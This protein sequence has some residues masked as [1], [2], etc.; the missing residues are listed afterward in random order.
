MKRK[1]HCTRVELARLHGR[2]P[3]S[4]LSPWPWQAHCCQSE[5]RSKPAF[6]F[7]ALSQ[8]AQPCDNVNIVSHETGRCPAMRQGDAQ[9]HE[10]L[11]IAEG[12]RTTGQKLSV[13]VIAQSRQK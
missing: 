4:R 5:A 9:P 10:N 6:N 8:D 12:D 3:L 7:A 1:R 2:K 11:V 13:E